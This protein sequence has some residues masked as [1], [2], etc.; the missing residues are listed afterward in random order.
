MRVGPNS[1]LPPKPVVGQV[2]LAPAYSALTTIT[3]LEHFEESADLGEWVIRTLAKLDR[4]TVGK[5][6]I[7]SWGLGAE[8]LAN[9]IE[10]DPTEHDFTAYLKALEL[11]DPVK[12]RDR[13]WH[14]RINSSHMR[15]FIDSAGKVIP[16]DLIK[17]K[18]RFVHF[19]TNFVKGEGVKGAIPAKVY[20]RTFDL[21]QNPQRLQRFLVNHLSMLWESYLAAEWAQIRPTLQEVVDAFQKVNLDNLPV[22]EM[23]QKVTRRDLRTIFNEEELLKF[24]QILFIPS[25]HNGPYIMWTGDEDT[26]RLTFSAHLPPGQITGGTG[27]SS[28]L[29]HTDLLNRFKALADENRIKILELLRDEGK[30]STQE[31]M[32]R[33]QLSKSAASRHLRQLRANSI[34]DEIRAADGVKKFYQLNS[35]N[36]EEILT[37]LATLLGSHN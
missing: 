33:L 31:V 26:L 27:S 24:N 2:K 19:F 18:E 36:G 8:T 13:I 23:I 10:L 15:V 9:A 37:G 29:N 21:L 3:L 32:E 5:Q 34:I 35:R 20:E 28:K 6:N 7:I 11:A 22:F 16:A 1:I 30:L 12:L 14:Y 25:V 17:D 4:E